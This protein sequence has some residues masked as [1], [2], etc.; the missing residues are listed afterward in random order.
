MGLIGLNDVVGS[1]ISSPRA[2]NVNSDVIRE[3][4]AR[5]FVLLVRTGMAGLLSDPAA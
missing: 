1:T 5:F 2:L 4:A 3:E